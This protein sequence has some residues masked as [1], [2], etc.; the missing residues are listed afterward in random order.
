[1]TSAATPGHPAPP[2]L[3]FVAHLDIVVGEPVVI[4]PTGAGTRRMVPILDGSVTGEVLSGRVLPGGLDLQIVRDDGTSD[5]TA[6][7]VIETDAGESVLV[8][9]HAIRSGTAADMRALSAGQPVDPARVYFHGCPR[10][11]TSAPRLT[12]L[13][14]RLHLAV[15]RREPDRVVLDVFQVG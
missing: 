12:T 3:R 4:G 11:E 14:H 9:N 2:E 5:L 6:R 10:F 1:M 7:Y 13:T 15:G 8:V